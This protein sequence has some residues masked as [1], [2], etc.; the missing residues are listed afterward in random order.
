VYQN[1]LGGL[2]KGYMSNKRRG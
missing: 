1:S 2:D